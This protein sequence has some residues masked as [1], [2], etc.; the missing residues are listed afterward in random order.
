MHKSLVTLATAW[1]ILLFTNKWFW[2]EIAH[3]LSNTKKID[4]TEITTKEIENIFNDNID[5]KSYESQKNKIFKQI[6][7]DT[8][9]N[10]Y[11]TD[12]ENLINKYLSQNE[13]E[14]LKNPESRR[15]KLEIIYFDCEFADILIPVKLKYLLWLT[16]SR[17]IN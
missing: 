15:H 4:Q 6:S 5:Y 7:S 12:L 13:N 1:T 16:N 17:V 3:I 8:T 9:D 2:Q 11:K 10:D 14:I